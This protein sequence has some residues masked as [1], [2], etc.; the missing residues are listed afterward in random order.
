MT[1]KALG[2]KQVRITWSKVKGAKKYYIYRSASKNSGYMRIASLKAAKR[3]YT[4]KK[5]KAGKKYYYKI[6]TQKSG[7]YSGGKISRAVKVKK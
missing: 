7:G 3:T 5:A 2:R 1:V 4:D 6:V